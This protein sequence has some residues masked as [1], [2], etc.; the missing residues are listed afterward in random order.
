M[1]SSKLGSGWPFLE[2]PFTQDEAISVE[3]EVRRV[4]KDDFADVRLVLIGLFE[5]D[6]HPFSDVMGVLVEL[7]KAVLV[8]EA[9]RLEQQLVFAVV[10]L[11]FRRQP[12]RFGLRTFGSV[13]HDSRL[14]PTDIANDAIGICVTSC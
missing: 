3:L 5:M 14:L 12:A 8:G 7:V 11:L 9:L 10:N 6:S 1:V 4:V 2:G 13:A